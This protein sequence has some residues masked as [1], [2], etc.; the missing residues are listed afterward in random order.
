M[1]RRIFHIIAESSSINKTIWTRSLLMAEW[2]FLKKSCTLLTPLRLPFSHFI[3]QRNRQGQG[4][5][6]IQKHGQERPKCSPSIILSTISL[7]PHTKRPTDYHARARIH[8]PVRKEPPEKDKHGN[9]ISRRVY[10]TSVCH[11]QPH[12]SLVSH[13]VSASLADPGH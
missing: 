10:W 2:L 3:G 7:L 5:L 4:L 1:A 11:H 8:L 12:D 13:S 6:G 9:L